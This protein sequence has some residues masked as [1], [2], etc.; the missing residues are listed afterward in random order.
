MLGWLTQF[1]LDSWLPGPLGGAGPWVI[2]AG[3]GLV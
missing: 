3:A 1:L 2:D